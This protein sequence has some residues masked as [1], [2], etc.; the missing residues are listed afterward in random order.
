MVS[1]IPLNIAVRAYSLPANLMWIG[2]VVSIEVAPPAA[3]EESLPKYFTNMGARSMVPNSLIIL[4]KRAVAPSVSPLI[5]V[6]F[7]SYFYY[8]H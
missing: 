4:D 1:T 6:I 7:H 2:S 3:I 5:W 8:F